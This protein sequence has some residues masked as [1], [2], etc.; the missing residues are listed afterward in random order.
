MP[1]P[2]SAFGANVHL[3][4][5]EG[6]N[7]R[8]IINFP[9][10]K[11][12]RGNSN[13]ADIQE[14]LKRLVEDIARL[15]IRSIAIPPLGCGL[16]GLSWDLVGSRIE[17][18]LEGVPQLQVF[19]Y[20]PAE[21][22]PA[23]VVTAPQRPRM[24]AAR[25]MLLW[26]QRCYLMAGLE[27]YSSLLALHKLMYLAEA[28][29]ETGL[30]LKCSKGPYGPYAENLRHMLKEL[31]GHFIHGYGDGGDSPHKEIGGADEALEDALVLLRTT[32]CAPT[33]VRLEKVK[34]LIQGLEDDHGLELL[35]SVHWVVK[36]EGAQTV[37][38]VQQKIG[39]WSDRKRELFSATHI[40][41]AWERWGEANWLEEPQ[42]GSLV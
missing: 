27:P 20:E 15:G 25:A 12:W 17:A 8:Y 19:L 38:Q 6:G 41:F 16:G 40:A 33:R 39:D 18:A 36:Q 32:G 1:A 42:Q 37:E 21:Q 30:R 34:A 11:H 9:T 5:R 31:D 23:A 10:K 26:L 4:S 35:T 22:D 3:R 14:G 7:P 13:I 24:T 28:A 2:G 29:G